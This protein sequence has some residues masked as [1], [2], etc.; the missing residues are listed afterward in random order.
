MQNAGG[1]K[2]GER[3]TKE[4]GGSR[5]ENLAKSGTLDIET[6]TEKKEKATKA[7]EGGLSAWLGSDSEAC[8]S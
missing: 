6:G 3:R 7:P 4:I 2:K 1:G 8:P 5:K